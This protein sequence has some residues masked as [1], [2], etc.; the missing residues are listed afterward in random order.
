MTGPFTMWYLKFCEQDSVHL[1]ED[2]FGGEALKKLSLDVC[3]LL[4]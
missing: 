2:T 1:L 4:N 3:S